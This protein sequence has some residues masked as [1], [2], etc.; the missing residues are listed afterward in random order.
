MSKVASYFRKAPKPVLH[1]FDIR[2]RAEAIRMAMA[3]SGMEFVDASFTGDDWGKEKPDGLKANWTAEGRL[4]FGQVPLLEIDGERLG[5]SMSILRYLGRKTK[6]YSGSAKA[7]A[8]ID[9]V[10]D[11]TEDVRKMISA[12][13]YTEAPLEEKASKVSRGGG[14]PRDLGRARG[15]PDAVCHGHRRSR[16]TSRTSIRH[17]AGW[18]I[19]RRYAVNT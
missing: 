5:Q 2:G 10:A 12:I 1:Y 8:K 15:Q 17:P 14:P 9:I 16:S 7:L 3:D 11:G 13:K 19:L 18:V 4:A 6:W